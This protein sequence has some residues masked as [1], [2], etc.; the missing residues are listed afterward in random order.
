M[1]LSPQRRSELVDA[2]RRGT[3]PRVGLDSFAVGL[4]PFAPAIDDELGS[5]ARG[6]AA[7]KAIRGDYGAG[8]T[9]T[10]RWIA[11]RAKQAGFAATEVQVSETETPLHRLETVY[12]RL[13]ERLSTASQ[14]S[15]ALRAIVD[16]WFYALEEEVLAGGRSPRTTPERSS[17]APVSSWTP[18]WGT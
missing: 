14:P 10:T 13:V 5:V 8:K 7:F 16:G 9:F 4:D 17:P 11:E 12:R 3:V 6:G 2:L 18:A 15:G 1:T